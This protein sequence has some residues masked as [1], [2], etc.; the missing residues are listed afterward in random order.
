MH[1]DARIG[2]IV[3]ELLH[4]G[5]AAVQRA[6][7]QRKRGHLI[8]ELAR[9]RAVRS[10]SSRISRRRLADDLRACALG[11]DPAPEPE[12]LDPL[13]GVWLVAADRDDDERDAER[14]RLLRAVE[15]AVRDEGRRLLEHGDLR[16]VSL[17]PDVRRRLTE[18]CRVLV[19]TDRRHDLDRLPRHRL[20]D[21]LEHAGFRVSDR[22]EAGEDQWSIRGSSSQAGRDS[23]RDRG[24]T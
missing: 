24:L 23:R 15:A 9:V 7:A 5:R 8:G 12:R 16:H 3:D 14:Q 17:D 20:E 13:G 6:T 19:A 1:R 18:S 22:P 4:I 21:R 10:G 11:A 2:A